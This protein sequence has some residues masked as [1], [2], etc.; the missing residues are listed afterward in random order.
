[1]F[2]LAFQIALVECRIKA[3]L[4]RHVILALPLRRRL[5]KMYHVGPTKTY[6]YG[7]LIDRIMYHDNYHA[8]A[9]EGHLDSLKDP[10]IRDIISG[11]PDNF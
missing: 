2:I 10:D 11:C 9:G 1:M 3:I 7:A 6:N 5:G 4:P 8:T